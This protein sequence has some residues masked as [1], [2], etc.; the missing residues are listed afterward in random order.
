MLAT[1]LM[2]R[3][4]ISQF[5]TLLYFVCLA[6]F[7]WWALS[8]PQVLIPGAVIFIIFI[9][10][11]IK[12]ISGLSFKDL[13]Y[14]KHL[15]TPVIFLISSF[16]FYIFFDTVLLQQI[17]WFLVCLALYFYIY[18][19]W[20]FYR[21][22]SSYQ[23][24]TLENFSWYLHLTGSWFF[25]S[26]I[27]GLIIFIN[28]KLYYVLPL[29]LVFISLVFWQMWWIQKL[30]H[31]LKWWWYITFMIICVEAFVT[32]LMLPLSFYLLGFWWSIIWFL[33]A[34]FIFQLVK[35]TM[36]LKKYLLQSVFILVLAVL[37][38]LTAKIF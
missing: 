4:T 22:P 15:I 21:R 30:Q 20:L 17:F 29:L 12:F 27:Y 19:L 2:N 34:N 35:E 24:F 23:V 37:L 3:K 28:L 32:L 25:I 6:V 11:L 7:G 33:T 26:S 5:V 31:K 16:I 36:V 18:N 14:Y 8:L 38:T 13:D 1:E 10:L 9:T